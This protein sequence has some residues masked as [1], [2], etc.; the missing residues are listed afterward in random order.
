MKKEFKHGD[1]VIVTDDDCKVLINSGPEPIPPNT[2]A[3]VLLDQDGHFL[4]VCLT[5]PSGRYK[6]KVLSVELPV[7]SVKLYENKMNHA[8]K[9]ILLGDAVIK[10]KNEYR[11]STDKVQCLVCGEL[12]DDA[13]H[14]H[15]VFGEVVDIP[16]TSPQGR[17]MCESCLDNLRSEVNDME[18]KI[19][20]TGSYV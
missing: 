11:Y 17:S 10:L 18:L 9:K 19:A 20:A 16:Q 5:F 7:E 3:R 13:I 6:G 14:S 12:C 1:I 4:F 15:V 2:F 8:S